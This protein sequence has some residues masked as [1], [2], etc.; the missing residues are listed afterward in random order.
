MLRNA[1][2]DSLDAHEICVY[3]ILETYNF[4]A[5]YRSRKSFKRIFYVEGTG[6][7]DE[8][9]AG[10][11]LAQKAPEAF[12]HTKSLCRVCVLRLCERTHC[13]TC[14]PPKSRKMHY[15]LINLLAIP[16]IDFFYFLLS[17]E[18]VTHYP[19]FVF[20]FYTLHFTLCGMNFISIGKIQNKNDF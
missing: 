7:H 2:S 16:A 6:G 10:C 1:F 9:V 5:L 18:P 15:H 3:F 8:D 4:W 13:S 11:L 12:D 17:L 20:V 19:C 14:W